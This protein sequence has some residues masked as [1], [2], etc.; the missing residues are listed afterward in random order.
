MWVNSLRDEK[1]MVDP[2]NKGI[3]EINIE[4]NNLDDTFVKDLAYFL[5]YDTWLR[6]KI[7]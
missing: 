1:T 5:K 7:V 3:I 4:N 2:I 6:V